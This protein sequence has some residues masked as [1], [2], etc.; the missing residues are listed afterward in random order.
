MVGVPGEGVIQAC[1]GMPRALCGKSS[2]GPAER[3]SAGMA[4]DMIP[5]RRKTYLTL[6]VL[7]R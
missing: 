7:P 5:I 4:G 2:V 3:N 1:L 6:M